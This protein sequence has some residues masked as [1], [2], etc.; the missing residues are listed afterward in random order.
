MDLPP[1]TTMSQDLRLDKP[2]GISEAETQVKT[3]GSVITQVKPYQK[4]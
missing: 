4:S 3:L 2:G 1:Q